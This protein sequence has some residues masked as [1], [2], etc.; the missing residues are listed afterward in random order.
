MELALQGLDQQ[1]ATAAESHSATESWQSSVL[2]FSEIFWKS[3]VPLPGGGY[4]KRDR[5][6]GR[7]NLNF[8]EGWIKKHPACRGHTGEE[9]LSLTLALKPKE[10]S[11]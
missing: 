8:A 6:Q 9:L 3:E 7:S 11:P 10:T 1:E 4:G 5:L 2:E